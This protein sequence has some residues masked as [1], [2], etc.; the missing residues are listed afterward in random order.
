MNVIASGSSGNCYHIEHCDM[1]I[2]VDI[3]VSRYKVDEILEKE[4]IPDSEKI[5]LFLTHEHHD[6]VSGLIPFINRY[7]PIVF[8]SEGTADALK[9]KKID[10]NDF[11]ILKKDNSYDFQNISIDCFQ[12]MHDSIEPLGYRLSLGEKAIT[13]ATD[14]GYASNYVED[15][16]KYSDIGILESNYDEELLKK[17]SYPMHLKKRILSSKGHLSNKE[18]LNIAAKISGFRLK[19]LLLGHVSEENNDYDLLRRYSDFATKNFGFKTHFLRQN[20]QV[21]RVEF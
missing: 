3:G 20:S 18:A 19:E 12:I 9:S 13:F 10:V 8:S 2:F 14:L 17:G 21:H 1:H 11:Y 6:H 5:L 7:N 15:F 4:D 16:L